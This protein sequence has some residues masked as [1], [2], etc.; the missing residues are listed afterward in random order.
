[1]VA[2]A[3]LLYP[4]LKPGHDGGALGYVGARILEGAILLTLPIGLNEM[5]LAL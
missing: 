4:I 3:V 2:I 1:M 5:A